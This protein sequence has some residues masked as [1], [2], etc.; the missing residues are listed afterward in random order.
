M[1]VRA[2]FM[3]NTIFLH[4]SASQNSTIPSSTLQK[5]AH[6]QVPTTTCSLLNKTSTPLK[7]CLHEPSMTDEI[8]RNYSSP[9]HGEHM[10]P[11]V[12]LIENQLNQQDEVR[13]NFHK[14]RNGELDNQIHQDEGSIPHSFLDF[15]SCPSCPYSESNVI[16]SLSALVNANSTKTFSTYAKD[17]HVSQTNKPSVSDET[18]FIPD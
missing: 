5:N 2:K 9:A 18:K 6:N 16:R 12:D 3:T 13:M 14:D 1:A 10:L 17:S 15:S 7:H 4:Q 8:H 11:E